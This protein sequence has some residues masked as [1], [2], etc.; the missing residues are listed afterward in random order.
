[1]F[2]RHRHTKCSRATARSQ[3]DG[4]TLYCSRRV[5]EADIWTATLN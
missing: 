5:T 2:I 4:R 1:V 3:H